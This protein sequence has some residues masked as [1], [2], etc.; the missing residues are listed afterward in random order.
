[1]EKLSF[2]QYNYVLLF[3]TVNTDQQIFIPYL[4]KQTVLIL[5]H[6]PVTAGHHRGRKSYFRIKRYFCRPSFSLDWYTTVRNCTECAKNCIKILRNVGA[7]SPFPITAPLESIS[8]EILGEPIRTTCDH[9][10][11]Q[12]VKSRLP[13]LVK[14]IIMKWLSAGEL[15]KIFIEHWAFN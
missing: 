1:M 5:S 2:V 15:A 13:K 11:T 12:V 6:H 10:H 8:I 3:H 4:L 9:K 7:M 14:A